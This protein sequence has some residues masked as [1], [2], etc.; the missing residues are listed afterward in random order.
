MI[1]S[2][3]VGKITSAAVWIQFHGIKHFI[4][5][6]TFLISKP[7]THTMRL[8]QPLLAGA[9]LI[10]ALD[11]VNYQKVGQCGI[12]A[13]GFNDDGD[14]QLWSDV[15]RKKR[16]TSLFGATPTRSKSGWTIC[17]FIKYFLPSIS[18]KYS[19]SL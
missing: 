6:I 2:P 1:N 19:N 14:T 10:N 11:S 12:P 13:K 4:S 5:K 15:N 3:K 18:A 9:S 16:S 17:S 8:I 7:N